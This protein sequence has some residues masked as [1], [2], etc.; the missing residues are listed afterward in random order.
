[1]GWSP[2]VRKIVVGEETSESID[3]KWAIPVSGFQGSLV[4]EYSEREGESR[5]Y[6]DITLNN[7]GVFGLL[8][9]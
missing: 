2:L 1:M 5:A 3:V 7:A 4:V 6:G 9:S 8:I